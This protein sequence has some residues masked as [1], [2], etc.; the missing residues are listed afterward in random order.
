MG[1]GV[2]TVVTGSYLSTHSLPARRTSGDHHR[3][4]VVHAYHQATGPGPPSVSTWICY[5]LVSKGA[6]GVA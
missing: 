4:Y 1:W 3:I 6:V 2:R 5:W